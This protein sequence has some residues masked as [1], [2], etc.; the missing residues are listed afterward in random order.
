VNSALSRRGIARVATVAIAATSIA[1]SG[2][3]LASPALADEEHAFTLDIKDL[4]PVAPGAD[5]VITYTLINTSDE[6]TDG[7]QIMVSAP[8]TV[9]LDFGGTR[10]DKRA[11]SAG[12]TCYVTGEMG[13]FAP[14]ETKVLEKS[15]RVAAT[16]PESASLGKVE[17]TVVPIVGGKPTEDK[18]DK[19]GPNTDSAEIT[20]SAGSAGA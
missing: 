19:D 18:N 2:A 20:T 5:G 8:K 12:T 15:Y 3:L 11:T 17:A 16:A 10:C 4:A 9:S 13:K 1:L 7:F 14:G 6:A